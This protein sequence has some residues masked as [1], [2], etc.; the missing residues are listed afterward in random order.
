[1]KCPRCNLKIL[2][3]VIEQDGNLYNVGECP[4]CHYTTDMLLMGKTTIKEIQL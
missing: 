4:E 3:S 1:M 2:F